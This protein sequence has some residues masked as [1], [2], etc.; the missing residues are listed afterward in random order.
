MADRIGVVVVG[1]GYA[2]EFLHLPNL[3]RIPEVRIVGIVSRSQDKA[4]AVAR[5]FG[6]EDC[7]TDFNQAL[8]REDVSVVDLNLPTFLHKDY[9]I[10]AAG[11]GKHVLCEKPMATTLREADEMIDAV[12]SAGTK[13]MIAHVLRFWPDYVK[14]KQ[15][16]E[17]G[18]VGEAVAARAKR[19]PGPGYPWEGMP[20][21]ARGSPHWKAEAKKGGGI[22]DLQIH[23]IDYLRYLFTSPIEVVSAVGGRLTGKTID[24]LDHSFAI[25]RLKDGR[26]WEVVSSWVR[27]IE[28]PFIQNLEVYG[29]EGY[30]VLDNQTSPSLTVYTRD[31]STLRIDP[32]KTDGYFDE[33]QHFV[34]CVLENRN[35]SITPEDS[36]ASLEASLAVARSIETMKPVSL[37]LTE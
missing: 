16:V 22:L 18:Y 27:P 14:V 19:I 3:A 9:V 12:K 2:T 35:P 20:K 31:G 34:K 15:L 32:P 24:A 13:L 8:K 33:I 17:E 7:Y 29:S 5:R 25:F 10:R 11:S 30:L 28:C 1:T 4:Q 6:I 36:R 37:P 23:D 21:E 26:V